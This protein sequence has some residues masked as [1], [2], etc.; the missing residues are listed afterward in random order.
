[1]ENPVEGLLRGGS[2]P[3]HHVG[4]L[5]GKAMAHKVGLSAVESGEGNRVAGNGKR[6]ALVRSLRR[7]KKEPSDLGLLKATTTPKRQRETKT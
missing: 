1:M 2:G 5:E 3:S 7:K 4:K 6:F